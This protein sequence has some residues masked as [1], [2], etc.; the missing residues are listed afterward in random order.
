MRIDI[1]KPLFAW[2]SLEDSPSLQ[3]IQRFL[4]ALPDAKLLEGLRRWRGRGRD[5]YP[6]HDGHSNIV[7]DEAGTVAGYDCTSPPMVRHQMAYIGHEPQRKTLKYR[8]PARHAGWTCPHD[9]AV[10]RRSW[11][12]LPVARE[13]WARCDPLPCRRPSRQRPPIHNRFSQWLASP[14]RR[15]SAPRRLPALPLLLPRCF[16]ASLSPL[17]AGPAP[18]PCPLRLLPRA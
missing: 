17:P 9:A 4:A 6:G 7:Y 18:P 14:W 5:D 2:E 13:P 15:K 12:A 16:F 8:C 3:T 11:R 10:W 1:P